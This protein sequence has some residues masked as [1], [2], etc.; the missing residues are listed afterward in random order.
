MTITV[1]TSQ[2]S[3]NVTTLGWTQL[4][5]HRLSLHIVVS[6][7]S[8]MQFYNQILHMESIPSLKTKTQKTNTYTKPSF[9][10]T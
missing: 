5:L 7:L 3:R 9:Q 2:Q 10:D 4:L 6:Q 8:S 1:I